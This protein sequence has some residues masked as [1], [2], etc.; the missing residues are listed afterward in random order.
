MVM[1]SCYLS[2]FPFSC[3]LCGDLP[4]NGFLH[5]STPPSLPSRLITIVHHT[6]RVITS[7]PLPLRSASLRFATS[8]HIP[9]RAPG[10]ESS[11]YVGKGAM[12]EGACG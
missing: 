2:V 6:R 5:S 9:W 7:L 4:S 10:G 12:G 1:V 3:V 11:R 8:A